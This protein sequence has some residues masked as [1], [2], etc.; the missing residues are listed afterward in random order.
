MIDITALI[1]SEMGNPEELEQSSDD[2]TYVL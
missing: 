2:L 1:L